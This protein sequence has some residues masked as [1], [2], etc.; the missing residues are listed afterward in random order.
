MN[1]TLSLQHYNTVRTEIEGRFFSVKE[2]VDLIDAIQART[3]A[4]PKLREAAAACWPEAVLER[5]LF[6]EENEDAR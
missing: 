3:I 2:A 6:D 5:G 4:D 1:D